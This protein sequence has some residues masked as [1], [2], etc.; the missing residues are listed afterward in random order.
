MGIIEDNQPEFLKFPEVLRK[1]V[2]DE[3]AAGNQVLE[4]GHGFPAA[5][6]GAYIKLASP[7]STR[8]RIATEEL[9]FYDR[10]S[11]INSGEFTDSNRHFFVLEP[12][13]PPKPAPDMNAIRAALDAKHATATTFPRPI[14]NSASQSLF[15]RFVKSM[16]MDYDK[17]REGEGYNLEILSVASETE[18]EDIER[19]LLQNTPLQWRDIEALAIIDSPKAR[20]AI[21]NAFVHADTETRMAVHRYAPELISEPMRIESIARALR[22]SEIFCGLSQALDDIEEFHPPEII[23]E[24]LR[25]LMRRDGA[26]ACHFAAMLYFLHG[27][28]N[29]AF[30]WEHR[31][32]FLKFNTDNLAERGAV[33][34]EL[35]QSIGVDA[36]DYL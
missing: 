14:Q 1:L 4:F 3:L 24:L 36:E 33:V 18:R 20:A 10:D 21:M 6:C 32:F 22:E 19:K 29:S 31:P 9:D 27:L 7:V 12:P 11:N 2:H 25:G 15:D 23:Q 17:W 5:P 8:E 30:D 35:C 16:E 13:N 26:T 34:R 28:S